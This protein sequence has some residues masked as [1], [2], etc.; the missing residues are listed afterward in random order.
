MDHLYLCCLVYFVFFIGTSSIQRVFAEETTDEQAQE[1]ENEMPLE[2]I[3]PS[4]SQ[5]SEYKNLG[6]SRLSEGDQGV[7]QIH[8]IENANYFLANPKHH[9]NDTSDNSQGTCTTV[10]LQMLVGYHTYYFDRITGKAKKDLPNDMH[11]K[12]WTDFWRCIFLWQK[13]ETSR[14]SIA[15]SSRDLL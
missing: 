5:E 12:S 10:A 3:N 6:S 2:N 11:P 13:K 1:Y 8:Y 15:Q 7:T 14:K 9:E 4:A